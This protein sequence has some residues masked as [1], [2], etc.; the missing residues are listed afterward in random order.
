MFWQKSPCPASPP[1]GLD[2][3]GDPQTEHGLTLRISCLLQITHLHWVPGGVFSGFFRYLPPSRFLNIPNDPSTGPGWQ[4]PYTA[5]Q[6]AQ[7]DPF[8][9]S[10]T[11]WRKS[12]ITV[13]RLETSGVRI[14]GS[15]H[16]HIASHPSNP[17]KPQG[18]SHSHQKAFLGSY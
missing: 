14:P 12:V 4:P 3:P 2:T 13:R 18:L 5:Q 9:F 10:L 8:G 6:I 15:P 17:A 1:S 16:P 7:S 11:H